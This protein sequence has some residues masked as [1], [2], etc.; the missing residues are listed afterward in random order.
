MPAIVFTA[1]VLF[2]EVKYYISGRRWLLIVSDGHISRQ[3]E[4]GW[5]GKNKGLTGWVGETTASS[6]QHRRRCSS[7]RRRYRV[8]I[9]VSIVECPAHG[10]PK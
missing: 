10:E 8:M 7:L 9:I 5:A 3:A 2:L 6:H 1:I 4:R